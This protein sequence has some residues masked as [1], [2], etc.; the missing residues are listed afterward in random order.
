MKNIKILNYRSKPNIRQKRKY[1]KIGRTLKKKKVKFE[2]SV[3]TESK[4]GEIGR[5]LLENLNLNNQPKPNFRYNQKN[6]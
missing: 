1:G 5:S 3:K 2:L 6:R 4:I